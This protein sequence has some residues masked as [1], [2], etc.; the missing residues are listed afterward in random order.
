MHLE[1]EIR[2]ATSL[3]VGAIT[4]IYNHAI[5]TTVATFDTEPKDE[6]NR[7][8]WLDNHSA[9]HPVLVAVYGAKVVG[10]ASIS[11]W[12]DRCAYDGTAEVS[13]YV[14]EGQR[15]RGVGTK[16]LRALVDAGAQA[17]L[18]VLL[19]RVVDGND[20]SVKLHERSGFWAIGSMKEVGFKF[21]RRRDVLLMQ[22]TYGPDEVVE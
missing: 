10:W 17:G 13:L 6:A 2:P 12:S 11:A 8:T 14:S 15:G 21:G 16:L 4:E 9:R 22:R 19:A 3:D 1:V 20:V 7:Q 5:A 18:H